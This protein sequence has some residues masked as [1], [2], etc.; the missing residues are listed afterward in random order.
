M[1]QGLRRGSERGKDHSVNGST[2]LGRWRTRLV[3][4]SSS[5]VRRAHRL[6]LALQPTLVRARTK[7]DHNNVESWGMGGP[8]RQN[9][10]PQQASRGR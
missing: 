10:G 6:D 3:R 5:T 2:R 4:G 9:L 1:L 7:P 8:R